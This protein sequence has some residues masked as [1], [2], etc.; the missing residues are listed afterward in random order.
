MLDIASGSVGFEEFIELSEKYEIRIC[1]DISIKALIEAKHN[2]GDRKAIFVCADITNIPI[3][4]NICDAVLCQHTLYHIP[5]ND[6]KTAV[7]EMLRVLKPDSKL[8]IVYS[9][10]YH[11]WFMNITLF[12]IQIYRI[13]RHFAGKLYVRLFN[14]KPRLYF[15]PHPLSWFTKN[16]SRKSTPDFYCWRSTNKYFLNL[17]IHKWLAGRWLLN[18]LMKSEKKH[19]KI[20]ARI[21]DYP[22]IVITK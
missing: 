20:W 15:Y 18:S 7:D 10:F 1:A 6:Q 5:K 3:M 17:Y 8:V 16:F 9:L 22:I 19:S 4:D 2:M 13:S 12:P 21:G 14:S 11:S